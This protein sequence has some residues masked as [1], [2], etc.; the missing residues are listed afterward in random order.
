VCTSFCVVIIGGIYLLSKHGE[1][2]IA[3]LVSAGPGGTVSP[4]LSRKGSHITSGHFGALMPLSPT[5]RAS[6][7]FSQ[8]SKVFDGIKDEENSTP[9]EKT[10]LI[11]DDAD[12]YQRIVV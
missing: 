7:I 8:S 1:D 2:D 6:L 3:H 12:H 4:A 10:A 9:S 5:H 11:D